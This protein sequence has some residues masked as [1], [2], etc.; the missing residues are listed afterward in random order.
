[1]TVN[2]REEGRSRATLLVWLDL[3]QHGRCLRVNNRAVNLLVFTSISHAILSW[4]EEARSFFSTGQE[5]ARTG[6]SVA[7]QIFHLAGHVTSHLVRPLLH[8]LWDPLNT[9]L[10]CSIR[11]FLLPAN[12]GA[13]L[14]WLTS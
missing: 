12:A 5:P 1:M 9:N 7:Q 11:R 13:G 6:L 8:W 3:I 10:N 2:W 4:C 14:G